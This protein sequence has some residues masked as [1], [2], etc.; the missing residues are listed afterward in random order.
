MELF[1]AMPEWLA[2]CAA[3]AAGAFG[4]AAVARVLAAALDLDAG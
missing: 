2:W 3:G 4:L 1:A